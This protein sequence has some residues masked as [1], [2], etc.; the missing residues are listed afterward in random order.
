MKHLPFNLRAI[1]RWSVRSG[2]VA[3]IGLCI[4]LV[5]ASRDEPPL[6]ISKATFQPRELPDSENAYLLAVEVAQLAQDISK[7]DDS[8]DIGEMLREEIPWDQERVDGWLSRYG[9]VITKFLTI[10]PIKSGQA[11]TFSP[12]LNEWSDTSPNLLT[13]AQVL[14]LRI[15]TL[16]E[17]GHVSESR[18]LLRSSHIISTTLCESQGNPLQ[19]LRPFGLKN[20][21]L[22]ELERSIRQYPVSPEE[23]GEWIRLLE[24][25]RP[26]K[27]AWRIMIARDIQMNNALVD[28]F[29]HP[30][31]LPE[32]W[33]SAHQ[34][35]FWKQ[36]PYRLPFL[37]KPNATK[38]TMLTIPLASLD[39]ID[40]TNPEIRQHLENYTSSHGDLCERCT[41]LVNR[42]GNKLA[43]DYFSF[44]ALGIPHR[45]RLNDQSRTSLV[46]ALVALRAYHD[47]HDGEMPET[48]DELVPEYLPLVPRDYYDGQPIKYSREL[49]ALWSAGPNELVLTSP[50]QDIRDDDILIPVRFDGDLRP[51][52][53]PEVETTSGSG[54]FGQASSE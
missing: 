53:K 43:H 45:M 10:E 1:A 14:M 6:D 35:T 41:D 3:F 49:K 27:E 8:Y 50:D 40:L 2:L 15:R 9:E 22:W 19:L 48:L 51:W 18:A 11:P 29:A 4:A 13:L 21:T 33:Y 5:L 44:S 36:L 54:L 23:A 20:A 28:A 31:S 25:S 52:K 46:Q 16:G 47:T 39:W 37:F 38:R 26:S 42:Y 12:P 32:E 30:D 34:K 24:S 7:D 17:T